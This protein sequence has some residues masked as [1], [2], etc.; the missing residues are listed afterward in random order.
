MVLRKY[1]RMKHGDKIK[2]GQERLRI[3]RYYKYVGITLHTNGKRFT[4]HIP[5]TERGGFSSISKLSFEKWMTL[6]I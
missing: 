2:Y 4:V 3:V 1:G 6:F 5:N